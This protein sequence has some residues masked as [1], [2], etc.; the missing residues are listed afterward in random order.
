MSATMSA[1]Y[2]PAAHA[3]AVDYDDDVVR[4]FVI[5]TIFWGAVGMAAGA[6]IAA[7]L[8]FPALNLDL[9][10]TTFGR[11]RPLHTS[12]VVFA[13]GG[14]AL[15]GT[16]LYVVQRT[17]R[18]RLAGRFAPEFMFWG[19]QLFIVMA[20]LGYVMGVTAG[21][22][23]AEPEWMTD[24][25]LAVVWLTYGGIFIG[26]LM[27]RKEPHIYVANWFT[28]SMIVT[29]T[30]L[31]VVNNL[32]LPV[33]WNGAKSYSLFS[34]VQDAMTQWWYGHNAVGFFLTAGFLGMMYYFLPKQANAPIWSYRLSIISFW[35][36]VFMY[37]W[38]GPHHLHYTSLPDWVQTLGMAF[39]IMLWM[40]SWASA[41]NGFMTVSG[42]WDLLRTDPILRFMV[43]AVLFYGVATFEGPLMGIRT[44]NGLS[45]YTDWT[46]SHVHSG[47]L[48][49][50]GFIV[51]GAL[52]YLVPK[53]WGRERMYSRTAIEWHFWLG[54]LG[55][56]LY[57]T[58]MW[59]SGVMQGLMWRAY[60]ELGFLRYSFLDGVVASQPYYVVRLLGGLLYLS[61]FLIMVWNII[62]T[63]SEVPVAR[64]VTAPLPAA[65]E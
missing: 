64:A 30:V 56:M 1:A 60:T 57:V 10:W 11:L 8:I 50:N 53:L 42:R 23:Y 28:L 22:E 16:S 26:T 39:T 38:A 2:R 65:A 52:Y 18:V 12:G 41:L 15:I 55:I 43:T 25:W 5:A 24:I 32:A 34:G 40:P 59:G 49:W 62:R 63:V 9:P 19:Y 45:H 46:I 35:S 47:A 33:Q 61:G 48:G 14:N 36:L 6:F 58:A 37:M 7:Q 4:L 54:L 21:R 17:C 31:H 51:F 3:E 29:V 27:R 13:F 44:I 20:A